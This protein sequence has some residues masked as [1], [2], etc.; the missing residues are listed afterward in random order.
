[1]DVAGASPMSCRF[2]RMF[3]L[4][5]KNQQQAAMFHC[6]TVCAGFFALFRRRD[7]GDF[8]GRS[9]MQEDAAIREHA[10]GTTAASKVM[11]N[12]S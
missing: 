3:F 11:K 8:P 7:R 9:P 2:L 1:M 12:A 4:R 10:K 5:G 6:D